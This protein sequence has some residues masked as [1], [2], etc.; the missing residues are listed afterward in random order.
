MGM[1]T[2]RGTEIEEEMGG[3]RITGGVSE[4]IYK[5]I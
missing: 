4:Y 5:Q 3:E 2:N 1:I